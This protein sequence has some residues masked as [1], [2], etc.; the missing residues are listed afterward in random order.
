MSAIAGAVLLDDRRDPRPFVSAMLDAMTYRGG[1]DATSRIVADGPAALGT[2]ASATTDGDAA[3]EIVCAID[4]RLD[5]RAAL[6]QALGVGAALDDRALCRQAYRR[7]REASPFRLLGDFAFA[8]WEKRERRLFCARDHFGI[9]P[10]YY[11]LGK[12]GLV[13]ASDVKAIVAS[14]LIEVRRNDEALRAFLAGDAMPDAT[15]HVAAVRSLPPGCTLTFV[16]GRLE[17]GR[18]DALALPPPYRGGNAEGEFL[19]LFHRAVAERVG[20]ATSL[21]SLLSGGL[22]SSAIVSLA[23][24]LWQSA[25]GA[26]MLTLS[27]VYAAADWSERRYIE[28]VANAAPIAARIEPADD[29]PPLAGLTDMLALQDGPYLAPGLLRSAELYRQAGEAGVTHLLDGHGGDEVVWHGAQRFRSL[30]AARRWLTLWRELRAYEFHDDRSSLELAWIL[31]HAMSRNSGVA[32]LVRQGARTILP[33]QAG[34]PRQAGLVVGVGEVASETADVPIVPGSREDHRRVLAM[35]LQ[36]QAFATFNR[37]AARHG[38]EPLYPFFDRRLVEFSLSLP[39]EEKM[40]DGWSRSVLRRALDG[41][42]PPEVQ[43]RRG[44]LNFAPAIGHNLMRFHRDE[45]QE[46]LLDREGELRRFAD[47][48]VARAIF[49]RVD[50]QRSAA[51]GDDIQDLWRTVVLARWLTM[52]ESRGLGRTGPERGKAADV[53]VVR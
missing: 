44:K 3:E 20:R 17:L 34:K 49:A 48:S 16:D 9:K 6:A 13:F 26:P 1:P 7:W 24:P 8:A 31:L 14:G 52:P 12:S 29:I 50:A 10:L 42:L 18:Y 19:A 11:A 2:L 4:A 33:R 25:S 37:A 40:R 22:D 43:W 15:T 30:A 28:A 36:E 39:D 5:D 21:A 53:A 45:I 38:V 51:S 41:R 35:P 46:A 23:A 27:H 32:R 47:L